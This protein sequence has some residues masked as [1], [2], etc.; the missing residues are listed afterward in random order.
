M[1]EYIKNGQYKGQ[2]IDQVPDNYL[3]WMTNQETRDNIF[4]RL[5]NRPKKAPRVN[6]W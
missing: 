3:L 6:L 5:S 4:T 1:I 2:S